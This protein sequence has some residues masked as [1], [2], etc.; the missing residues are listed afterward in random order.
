[1]KLMG[2]FPQGADASS[3]DKNGFMFVIVVVL[4]TDLVSPKGFYRTGAWAFVVH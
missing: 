2:F 1:M 3:S 4:L